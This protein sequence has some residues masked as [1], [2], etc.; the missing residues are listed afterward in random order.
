M[1][2]LNITNDGIEREMNFLSILDNNNNNNNN[3]NNHNNN[4]NI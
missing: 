4:N 2:R 3:N 1:W